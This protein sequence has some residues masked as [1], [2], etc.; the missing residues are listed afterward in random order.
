MS[1]VTG[2]KKC[3]R[4]SCI[5]LR[6]N[7]HL[8]LVLCMKSLSPDDEENCKLLI[9]VLQERLLAVFSEFS[10]MLDIQFPCLTE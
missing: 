7:E 4:W 8:V 9:P 2:L 1:L 3:K 10:L 5:G 6:I